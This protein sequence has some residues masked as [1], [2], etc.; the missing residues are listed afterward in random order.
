MGNEMKKKIMVIDDLPDQL[1]TIKTALEMYDDFQVIGIENGEQCISYLKNV[2]IPDIILTE[3]R[4]PGM[5]GLDIIQKIREN[6][7][8]ENIPIAFLTAWMDLKSEELDRFN[9]KE[10]I[11]KP[12]DMLDL[13]E[14]IESMLKN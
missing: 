10:I 11:E 6:P 9:V 2:E 4:M 8:W 13:K 3:S 5:N 1:F 14:R 12:F 7:L